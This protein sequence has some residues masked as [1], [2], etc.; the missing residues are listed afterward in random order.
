[1]QTILILLLFFVVV[2]FFACFFFFFFFF[3]SQ[4]L[5]KRPKMDYMYMPMEIQ[6]LIIAKFTGMVVDVVC[7][8]Q[9]WPPIT[10]K[11]LE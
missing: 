2:V 1:M 6:R 8:W 5:K 4:N 10:N 11:K 3:V 9:T 7:V